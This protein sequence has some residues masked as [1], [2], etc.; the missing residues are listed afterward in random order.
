MST[1]FPGPP[2]VMGLAKKC[3]SQMSRQKLYQSMAILGV[4][5]TSLAVSVTF[6]CLVQWNISFKAVAKLNFVW[7]KKL[8]SFML[9]LVWQP[10]LGH[11]QMGE[12]LCLAILQEEPHLGQSALEA[13]RR[14]AMSHAIRASSPRRVS[15]IKVVVFQGLGV[16]RKGVGAAVAMKRERMERV[17]A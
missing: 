12:R 6:C 17:L 11:L 4:T 5:P 16:A 13:R 14:L 1:I 9:T 10:F 15:S 3:S 2:M 8:P 7:K